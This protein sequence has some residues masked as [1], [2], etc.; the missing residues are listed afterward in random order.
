MTPRIL[1]VQ[2]GISKILTTHDNNS[3]NQWIE[4]TNQNN[5]N[6]DVTLKT[7]GQTDEETSC[8]SP[9]L[10]IVN[11]IDGDI[12]VKPRSVKGR[13]SSR[14]ILNKESGSRT[15]SHSIVNTAA[16]K[17]KANSHINMEVE[18]NNDDNN[19]HSDAISFLLN[20]KH[21]KNN[22]NSKVE[23]YH[24][25]KYE[26]TVCT[27]KFVGKSNLIDHLRYHANIRNFKCTHCEKSFV[28][29]GR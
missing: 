27:K 22:E 5:Q 3:E 1:N 26:C 21:L 19:D 11:G 4:I 16:V 15:S 23:A 28:Q 24:N 13:S 10:Y 29:S 25:R 2:K 12:E 6:L 9:V 17:S 20:N 18:V 7:E 14:I 8:A